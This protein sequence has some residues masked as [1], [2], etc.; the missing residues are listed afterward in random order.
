VYEIERHISVTDDG[1]KI[2]HYFVGPLNLN[3]K[4]KKATTVMGAELHL[5]SDEFDALD[6]L[7]SHEGKPLKFKL[8]YKLVWD[9][10]ESESELEIARKQLNNLL[11]QVR[12]YGEGFMWI[13]HEPQN[14]YTFKT[15]WGHNWSTNKQPVDLDTSISQQKIDELLKRVRNLTPTEKIVFRYILNNEKYRTT[16]NEMFVT[17]NTVRTHVKNILP[18][19]RINSVNEFREYTKLIKKHNLDE[20]LLFLPY[21]QLE[22]KE[23]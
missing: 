13:E 3:R 22:Q 12:D 7:A 6:I 17:V 9:D 10:T 21:D 15:R 14:G 16:A 5:S 19:L 11:Q 4:T 1:I 18:K 23:K 2:T 20:I 8:L